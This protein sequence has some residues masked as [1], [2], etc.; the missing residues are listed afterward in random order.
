[1][2]DQAEYTRKLDEWKAKTLYSLLEEDLKDYLSNL[3]ER[4]R[5]T[6]QEFRKLVQATR[7][8]KMW[9]ELPLSE[10]WEQYENEISST[11]TGQARKKAI[12]EKLQKKISELLTSENSYPSAGLSKPSRGA[13]KILQKESNHPVFGMCPVAS[14][15]TVCCNLRTIDVVENCAYGCSY[16]TIQTF[17]DDEVVFHENL[18]EKLN[19]IQ[20]EADRFYHIGT[21]QS[22][23]SLV[24]GN[25]NGLLDALF[26]FARKHPNVLLE[27]KTK[28]ANTSYLLEHN[29]PENVVCSW[30]LNTETIADNE[31]HFTAPLEQRLQAAKRVTD[32]GIKVAFHF[33]PII[34]YQG[35]DHEYPELGARVI[36]EFDPDN[37]LF[38][39]F[40]SMTL[41]KPVIQKIRERGEPTKILQMEMFKDPHGKLT[42]SDE[43]KLKLFKTMNDTFKPWHGKVY[44]YL[45]MERA[46]FWDQ[47]FGSHYPTN[48]EF[49]EDFGRQVMSKINRTQHCNN[50]LI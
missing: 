43:I 30:S 44:R 4:Y 21:G 2:E 25:R 14:E 10:Y 20:L 35:W 3:S 49:E 1:M 50:Q 18:V 23:D 17:Y 28:S 9:Q 37:V 26:N 40:G 31:E 15:K 24:W 11:L 6:F 7:D 32:K 12:L 16:C 38:I 46:Y 47:V 42:Y 13:L 19:A 34:Y 33:H 8:L 48:E 27:L 22:S 45:C 5:F 41:I 39:S 36:S 29:V